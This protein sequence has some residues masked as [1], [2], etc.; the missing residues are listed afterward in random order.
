MENS[1]DTIRNRTRDPPDCS[2]VPQPT[3]P[4]RARTFNIFGTEL[5][6]KANEWNVLD[7]QYH[8]KDFHLSID[9]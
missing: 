9:F 3:T 2:A 4:P 6:L 1:N 8:H 7:W 5:K